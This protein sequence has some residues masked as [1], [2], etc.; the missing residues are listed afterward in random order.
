M[1]ARL[2]NPTAETSLVT[3]Y[4]CDQGISNG[5]NSGLI[6]VIDG[7]SYNHNGTLNNFALNGNTSNWV[8]STP[9]SLSPIAWYVDADGDGYGIPSVSITTCSPPSGYVSNNLDCNDANNAAHPGAVEIC[10][11]NIDDN[12]NGQI[13]ENCCNITVN[14]GPDEHLLYGYPPA[15]CKSKTVVITNGN[16][17]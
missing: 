11:N 1:S 7:S 14:A 12:C 3:Y 10:G 15:Q 17:L 9:V 4:P 2:A 6:N 16:G 13:D 8:G 5:N